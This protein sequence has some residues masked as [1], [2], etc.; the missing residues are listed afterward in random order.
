V[1]KA[2]ME[3]LEEKQWFTRWLGALGFV[4]DPF[5]HLNSASDPHLSDY[6]VGHQSFSMAWDESSAAIFA[7]A[8]GGKT[9]MRLYATRA[10][11]VGG[12]RSHALPVPYIP[13]AQPTRAP[14]PTPQEHQLGLTRA[15]A[16]VLML[17]FTA[18]PNLFLSQTQTLRRNIASLLN[19]LLPRPLAFYISLL[20]TGANEDVRDVSDMLDRSYGLPLQSSAKQLQELCNALQDRFITAN[21]QPPESDNL[22]DSTRLFEQAIAY[23]FE[24]GFRSVHVL[25]D[26]VDGAD[27]T[28]KNPE[29]AARSITWLYEQLDTWER[30]HIFVKGFLPQE[31]AGPL[32]SELGN[33]FNALRVNH[34]QWTPDLLAEVIRRRVYVATRGRFG[35]LDGFSSPALRDVDIYLARAARSLPRDVIV[36]ARRVLLAF[37][38]R[39][40]AAAQLEPQDIDI[41]VAEYRE[42]L[43]ILGLDA[44]VSREYDSAHSPMS[45][46]AS[47]LLFTQAGTGSLSF[48]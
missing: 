14:I 21:D 1:V 31:L 5:S 46:I 15:I 23:A 37:A 16:L 36:L 45:S 9:A 3:T 12:G 20:R 7:P 28:S 17:A 13:T 38:Q 48:R 30:Q 4:I 43:S 34:L 22:D 39:D 19:R 18:F 2:T 8:G 35:S 42:E 47:P 29:Q 6:L 41:A 25:I 32:K 27:D 10:S 26:G 44:P 11:W 40:P 24:L 33:T